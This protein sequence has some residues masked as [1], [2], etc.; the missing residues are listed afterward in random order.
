MPDRTRTQKRAQQRSQAKR[1]R[2]RAETASPALSSPVNHVQLKGRLAASPERRQLPSGDEV[3]TFRLVV[4]R[5]ARVKATT[6]QRPGVDTIDCTIWSAGL[7]RRSA[8][9]QAG[10]VLAVEGALRRHFW[11]SVAGPRSRYD[12]EVTAATRVPSAVPSEG[13]RRRR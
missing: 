6:R 8:S 4:P 11:R 13:E 7:R 9:W 10:E 5:V 12:V 1:A 2:P 3:V